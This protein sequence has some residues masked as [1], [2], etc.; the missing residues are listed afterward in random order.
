MAPVVCI[1]YQSQVGCKYKQIKQ[2]SEVHCAVFKSA[3]WNVE[4]VKYIK[5]FSMY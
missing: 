5:H 4:E 2:V 3:A 1:H